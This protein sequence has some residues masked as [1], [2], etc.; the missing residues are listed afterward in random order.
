MSIKS[1]GGLKFPVF[2][3]FKSLQTP[4]SYIIFKDGDV[5]KAKNGETGAIEFSGTDAATIIQETINCV[6]SL[7]GGKV[8]IKKGVYTINEMILVPN[9]SSNITIE[10]EDKYGV[11]LET[12]KECEYGSVIRLGDIGQVSK[13]TVRNLTIRIRHNGWRW[14]ILIRPGESSVDTDITIEDV[15][16]V[17]DIGWYANPSDTTSYTVGICIATLEGIA[18]TVERYRV[19]NCRVY[20]FAYGIRG[21]GANATLRD[22]IIEGNVVDLN[23]TSFIATSGIIFRGENLIIRSNVVKRVG[24]TGIEAA[25]ADN[26]VIE[27]NTLIDASILLS[28]SIKNAVVRGNTIITDQHEV[29]Q[30]IKY[31]PAETVETHNIVVEGNTLINSYINISGTPETFVHMRN[32]IIKG[33]AIYIGTKAAYG[34]YIDVDPSYNIEDL[35]I[36][37]NVIRNESD[38]AEAVRGIYVSGDTTLTIA[39]NRIY[40]YKTDELALAI[41]VVHSSLAHIRN[42]II[43]GTGSPFQNIWVNYGTLY[44]FEENDFEPTGTVGIGGDAG[45][46]IFRRNRNY[47][48]ENSGTATIIAGNTYVDVAHGL[49]GAPDISKVRVTPRDDLGGR[50][51]WV[52][53]HPTDPDTYFRI[54]IS[55]SDSVD[56]LFNWYAE[57]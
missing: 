43:R 55:S 29:P 54:Y 48:T 31:L 7:G 19:R 38:V 53:E 57:I 10:G 45:T 24:D 33:N 14:G 42:N 3:P 30:F 11:V 4:A 51:F 1:Y 16:L 40:L 20:N 25:W 28:R 6:A 56:H 18:F 27:G 5:V 13:I 34:I 39:N 35:T 22:L 49:A 21:G 47:T 23:Q 37:D 32:I 52:E 44:I 36:I 46:T 8:L 15:N 2:D 41:L 50:S 9:G 26:V 17:S 12:G